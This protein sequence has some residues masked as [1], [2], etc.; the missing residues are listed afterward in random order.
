MIN[1][2]RFVAVL[3]FATVAASTSASVV[4]AQSP[5]AP[6]EGRW[7][8]KGNHGQVDL[9]IAPGGAVTFL[10]AG[11]PVDLQPPVYS[12]GKLTLKTVGGGLVTTIVPDGKGLKASNHALATNA[13]WDVALTKAN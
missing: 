4:V 9:T 2:R 11:K 10:S 12:D 8:G 7:T 13:K 5:S 6:F 1:R 3:S